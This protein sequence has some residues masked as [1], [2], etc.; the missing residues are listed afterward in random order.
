[1]DTWSVCVQML[2]HGSIVTKHLAATLYHIQQHKVAALSRNILQ[3]PCTIYNN[4][5]WQHCHETSCSNPVPYTTTQ[6]GSIVTKH[7]AATLYHIQQHKVAA[8]SRNILQQPCTIYNNTRWQHCHETSCSNPVPYTTT[9]GGSIVTKHLAAT[10]YH[11]QQHKVAALSRNILQQPCTIY[12]NTRWQHCH[13][14]SCSNPVPY[15]TTQGGSIVTKHLAATLYHI[16]QH[17]VAALS[18]NILQQPCTIYNNTRWQ[19]CHETSCSNPVPYTTTQGGSI[20]TKHLAATL[21]H[22]QQ[23]KVAAL[24]RNILQQPCTIYNKEASVLS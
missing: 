16:Q 21:Y 5:R 12:N 13:E 10:L 23:H 11:I 3:Q 20:V 7:L 14:T 24:S 2:P 1:M 18:R 4:T 9:Q 19:H 6:G 22:I 17:K 8:L 15:T